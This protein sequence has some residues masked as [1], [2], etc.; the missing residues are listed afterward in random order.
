M[1]ETVRFFFSCVVVALTCIIGI[2]QSKAASAAASKLYTEC[3]AKFK[4]AA[5]V[6]QKAYDRAVEIRGILGVG[7]AACPIQ[8]CSKWR[9]FM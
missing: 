2:A 8:D 6:A 9:V 1:H 5:Q 4:I 7:V 3:L